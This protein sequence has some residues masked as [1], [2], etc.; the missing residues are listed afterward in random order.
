MITE[1][2]LR[3]WARKTLKEALSSSPLNERI[4]WQLPPHGKEEKNAFIRHLSALRRNRVDFQ[5]HVFEKPMTGALSQGWRDLE[6]DTIFFQECLA[7][8][9]REYPGKWNPADYLLQCYMVGKENGYNLEDMDLGR[10]LR[11]LPS[12]LREYL[13]AGEANKRSDVSVKIPNEQINAK[14]H[15]D[16]VIKRNGEKFY[17]WSYLASTRSIR[18]L[19]ASKI[20]EQRGKVLKGNNLLAPFDKSSDAKSV[21]GWWIPTQD[22]IDRL[23]SSTQNEPISYQE[24]LLNCEKIDKLVFYDFLKFFK[25]V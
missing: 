25:N 15:V 2:T 16:L 12:F 1:E 9:N 14:Y 23:L 7:T 21:L 22:Y 20:T 18:H 10:A 13:I 3:R 6:R 17:I 8:L 5:S 24:L 11:N 19:T 4:N